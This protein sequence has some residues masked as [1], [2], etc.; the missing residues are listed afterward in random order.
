MTSSDGISTFPNTHFTLFPYDQLAPDRLIFFC[1]G[2][3]PQSQKIA[4]VYHHWLLHTTF[5]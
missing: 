3:E 2:N 1:P 5:A 4:F